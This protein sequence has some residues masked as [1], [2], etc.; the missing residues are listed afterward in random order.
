[1]S[2]HYFSK[3]FLFSRCAQ[4]IS[5]PFGSEIY[6][7]HLGVRKSPHEVSKIAP[8]SVHPNPDLVRGRNGIGSLPKLRV[9][10]LSESR[11]DA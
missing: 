4:Q 11:F 10:L 2:D 1:M 3:I 9:A 5:D 7:V 6:R 8:D